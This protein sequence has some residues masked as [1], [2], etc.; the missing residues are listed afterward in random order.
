MI[1]V[2]WCVLFVVLVSIAVGVFRGLVRELLGLAGWVLAVVL[3]W[4]FSDTV[5]GYLE[6]S[7]PVPSLRL[8]LAAALLFA[9]GLFIGAVAA[10]L[11]SRVIQG[12]VLAT[13]DRA[14]GAGFGAVRGVLFAALFVML[15]GMTPLK[16]D[17]WWQQSLFVGKLEW[18]AGGLETLVPDTWLNRLRSADV[19]ASKET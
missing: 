19:P 12:T 17:P 10:W 9:G 8:L 13:P 5:A 1:W 7:V 15:A 16:R 18:L 2:D 4:Q 11:V 14:L 6:S 3:A